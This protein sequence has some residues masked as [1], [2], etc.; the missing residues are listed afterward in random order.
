M[1]YNEF[2]S[3][4]TA[5]IEIDFQVA[6]SMEQKLEEWRRDLPAYFTDPDVPR[7]F[8]GPRA[9]VMW[10]EQNLRAI[11]WRGSKQ[12]SS[13]LP[14]NFEAGRRCLDAVVQTIHEITTF[15]RDY[16][17]LLHRG[18]AWYATYFLFQATLA[19]EASHLDARFRQNIPLHGDASEVDVEWQRCISLARDCLQKLGKISEAAYRCLEVLDRIHTHF[20]A[21]STAGRPMNTQSSTNS[22]TMPQGPPRS[23]DLHSPDDQQFGVNMLSSNG[24]QDVAWFPFQV[25]L[26][27]P[28]I[29]L[30]F[31]GI[32]GLPSTV[33]AE[34]P[35]YMHAAQY[36]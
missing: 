20:D 11:L 28:P 8:L 9:M 25:L 13:M 34:Y 5:N 16:V 24:G 7:W 22:D 36:Y 23:L 31:Q 17:D 30:F 4:K 26:E 35:G 21:T 12:T 10:K 32:E 27:C 6:A 2:L 18:L 3:A 14:S 1:I 19:L 29:D 15:C 33:D